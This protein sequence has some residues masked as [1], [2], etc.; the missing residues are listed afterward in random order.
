MTQPENPKD[1]ATQKTQAATEEQRTLPP[2][3]SLKE[4]KTTVESG[5]TNTFETLLTVPTNAPSAATITS[6]LS[7]RAETK[8]GGSF[9]DTARELAERVKSVRPVMFFGLAMLA[10]AGAFAYFGWWTKA[11]IAGG[12]GVGSIVLAQA[13]PGN[14]GKIIL[15]ALVAFALL[16][17]LVLYVYHKGRLDE[18]GKGI[19]E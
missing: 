10:V 11:A 8:I 16:A 17:L 12:V 7:D 2:G 14:E 19:P 5:H 3:A 18:N 15:V 6:K 4:T 1:S 9:A 13:L